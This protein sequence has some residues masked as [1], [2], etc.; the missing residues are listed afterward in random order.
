MNQVKL[1]SFAEI[2]SEGMSSVR[3]VEE[4]FLVAV[5]LVMICTS[6]NKDDAGRVLRSIEQDL[7]PDSN[8]VIRTLP[9]Q[10]NSNLKTVDFQ[11]AIKLIMVIPG[12]GAKGFRLK[13]TNVIHRFL[14]GDRSLIQEINANAA[15]SNPIS[16]MARASL[17]G[18]SSS[19]GIVGPSMG[20][21]FQPIRLNPDAGR[22]VPISAPPFS[23][24]PQVERDRMP[25]L[26]SFYDYDNRSSKAQAQRAA[27]LDSA[28]SSL[29]ARAAELDRKRAEL[30]ARAAELIVKGTELDARADEMA[31]KSAELD[32]R[33]VKLDRD[34]VE[35]AKQVGD[36]NDVQKELDDFNAE[37]DRRENGLNARKAEMDLF[38][39]VLDSRAMEM[40]RREA[41]LDK[42]DTDL[43][44]LQ[45][46]L[47][48]REAQINERQAEVL[49]ALAVESD[50]NFARLEARKAEIE[51]VAV[52][53]D[54]KIKQIGD[55]L[56]KREAEL[57][58]RVVELDKRAAEL[59]K[60]DS[61]LSV[62]VAE[63]VVP[64]RK[65]AREVDF[66]LVT[67]MAEELKKI[68]GGE[69]DLETKQELKQR[70]FAMLERAD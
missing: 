37:L 36:A 19:G 11:N 31:K 62:V 29:N 14:A 55:E 51:A 64:G 9:G 17:A 46:A 18:S 40:D 32:A 22:V 70:L 68:Y 6:R 44:E 3:I 61:S 21:S 56:D 4:R 69:L 5:D 10:G 23:A 47:E 26:R 42:R 59:D 38:A 27:S 65:R 45:L 16:Q 43:K 25:R 28:Q 58:K 63:E 7:F 54:A 50:R 39:G 13:F 20:E 15:S 49:R 34:T 1:F 41:G 52:E 48:K 53:N 24:D 33:A 2:V 12:K 30:D 67:Q 60:A 35:L 57:K 66:S 8:F